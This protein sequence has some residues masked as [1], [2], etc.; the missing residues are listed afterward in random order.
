MA[1]SAWTGEARAG[2]PGQRVEQG[3]RSYIFIDRQ[4]PLPLIV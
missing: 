4:D 2:T 1:D 3:Q